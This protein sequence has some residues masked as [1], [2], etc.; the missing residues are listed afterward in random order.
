MER[1]ETLRPPT[2]KKKKNAAVAKKARIGVEMNVSFFCFS[3]A[4]RTR[5]SRAFFGSEC[6]HLSI[7][8]AC[9]DFS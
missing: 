6:D 3:V 1:F 9:R 7:L 4:S 8:A 5:L 2:T